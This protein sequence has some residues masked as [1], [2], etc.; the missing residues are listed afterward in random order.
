[1][2]KQTNNIRE[3]TI[4]LSKVIRI[5]GP[6]VWQVEQLIREHRLKACRQDLRQLEESL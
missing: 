1:M 3:N 4:F 6:L 2:K 5:P